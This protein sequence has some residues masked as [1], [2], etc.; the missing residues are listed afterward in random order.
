MSESREI[1]GSSKKNA[2]E[3]NPS[4]K[5]PGP[6][7]RL[8]TCKDYCFS[9]ILTPSD[10]MPTNPELFIDACQ[11]LLTKSYNM[12]FSHYVTWQFIRYSI[13]GD[14]KTFVTDH[15]LKAGD[16]ISFYRFVE[17]SDRNGYFYVLKFDKNPSG[18]KDSE[19]VSDDANKRKKKILPGPG[20][21]PI[22][23]EFCCLSK[24]ITPYEVFG[25]NPELYLDTRE[26]VDLTNRRDIV[27]FDLGTNPTDLF[28]F[29]KDD[30]QYTMKLSHCIGVGSD[31]V[32]ALNFGWG[33]FLRIHGL[34][35]GDRLLFYRFF[36]ESVCEDDYYYALMSES[37]DDLP[38]D[39]P[40]VEKKRM[41]GHL[42]EKKGNIL[43]LVEMC[44]LLEKGK[45]GAN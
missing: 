44:E 9:R 34:K 26:A 42:N 22:P 15:N 45:D 5:W 31:T 36:H 24:I 2:P 3:E 28:V 11:G 16:E 10:V 14:W 35:E 19:N 41:L 6:M 18:R 7:N 30:R 32:Y 29:D 38:N 1:H 43:D 25:E 20:S 8:F 12:L 39:D 33:T 4:E 17:K 27:N 23:I 40:A 13:T 37:N 21:S